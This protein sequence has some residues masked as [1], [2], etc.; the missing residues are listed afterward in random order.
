MLLQSREKICSL[1]AGAEVSFFPD[2]LQA[3][4]TEAVGVFRG[5][6]GALGI[7]EADIATVTLRYVAHFTLKG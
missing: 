5:D 6:V 4:G 1:S 7:R 2:G 3:G